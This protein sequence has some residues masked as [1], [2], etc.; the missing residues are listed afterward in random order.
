MLH[1][2]LQSGH[3]SALRTGR[4][5]SVDLIRDTAMAVK[6]VV[7]GDKSR[8]DNRWGFSRGTVYKRDRVYILSTLEELEEAREHVTQVLRWTGQWGHWLVEWAV[9]A[10]CVVD[11]PELQVFCM[12]LGGR[13]HIQTAG[14]SRVE[15][16]DSSKEGPAFRGMLR[17]MR[18]VGGNLYVTGMGRQ[19]YRRSN[20]GNWSRIDDGVVLPRGRAKAGGFNSIDGFSE[21]EIYAVGWGGEIWNFDGTTW[22]AC[23]S[24]TNLILERVLCA[25]DGVVYAC[26]QRGTLVAGRTNSWA[27]AVEEGP[28]DDFW[29]MEWFD[30]HLW[31]SALGGIFVR[32][33]KSLD[34]ID[35]GSG[36]LSH[37]WLSAGDGVI[38]SIGPE[39]LAFFDGR[40]WHEVV[41]S[42]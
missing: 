10:I 18:R 3:L 29:G 9:G 21:S 25:P 24:P 37:G 2:K 13:I 35:T 30:G 39:D 19:V 33:G 36:Q 20:A 23:S 40:T 22:R 8:R 32:N 17:D 7:I 27:I 12:G 31:V 14:A 5:D 6:R 38:W 4:V 16:V 28:E 15:E 34:A 26:G 11:Q 1:A 41:L 42:P